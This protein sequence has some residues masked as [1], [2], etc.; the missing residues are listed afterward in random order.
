MLYW[1][2]SDD[3]RTANFTFVEGTTEAVIHGLQVNTVYKLRVMAV[4][5]GGDGK[6]SP[7][8]YFTVLRG[9]NCLP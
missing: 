7:T 8:I 6:R 5:R 1:P 3:L 9:G 2:V 4:N